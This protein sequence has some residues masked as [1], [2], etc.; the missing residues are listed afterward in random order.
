[1]APGFSMHPSELARMTELGARPGVSEPWVMEQQ[2]Q[3]RAYEEAAKASWA[4]EF[5]NAPQN[6]ASSQ[7][8]QQQAIPGRPECMFRF[9]FRRIIQFEQFY[10]PT[11]AAAYVYVCST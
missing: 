4:A 2:H 10:S 5:G 9:F 11:A 8:M 1:M 6:N 7:S 3:M